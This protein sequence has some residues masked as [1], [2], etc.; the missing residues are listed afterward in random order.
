MTK[1]LTARE[2]DKIA[3][4]ILAGIGLAELSEKY[5]RSRDSIGKI[6]ANMLRDIMVTTDGPIRKRNPII[7]SVDL[8]QFV[9]VIL[10]RPDAML[11]NNASRAWQGRS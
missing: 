5:G 2:R 8:G 9:V 10:A 3:N 6:R 11:P 1:A 4:D 7:G